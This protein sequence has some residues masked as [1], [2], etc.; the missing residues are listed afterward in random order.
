MSSLQISYSH[1]KLEDL[2]LKDQELIERAVKAMDGA[3]APYSNFHV[4]SAVLLADGQIVIGNNQENAA[5]PS[6]LCA[7]RVA[8]FAAMSNSQQEIAAIAIVARNAKKKPADAFACGSCRQVMLE[9]AS[10]Q[11]APIRVVMGDHQGQFIV[12]DDVKKLL[13]FSFDFR[14]LG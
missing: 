5:Y 3:H 7:E 10:K 13:P 8:L 6:G 2:T 14:T 1:L 11:E 12:L 4:G 9:Y